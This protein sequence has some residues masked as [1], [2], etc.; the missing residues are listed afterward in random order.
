MSAVYTVNRETFLKKL[1]H[2]QPG[3]SETEKDELAQTTHIVFKSG[4]AISFNAEVSCRCPS[5]LEKTLSAAVKARPLIDSLQKLTTR[6]I[7][8]TFA[9]KRLVVDAR[10]RKI[11]VP[12][13]RKIQLKFGIVERPVAWQPLRDDFIEAIEMATQCTGKNEEMF[14]T[15]C[16]HLHPKGIEACDSFQVLRYKLRTGVR[17]SVLVRGDAIKHLAEMS[18]M[19]QMCET[20]TWIHFKNKR[21]FIFSVRRHFGYKY[22]DLSKAIGIE[23]SP[24]V[25]PRGLPDEIQIAE[26]FSKSEDV[27]VVTV[28]IDNG[29]MKMVGQGVQGKFIGGPYKVKYKGPGVEFLVA[30]NLLS[31]IVKKYNRCII[32]R[33]A[34]KIEGD[35]W[36]YLCYLGNPSA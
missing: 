13:D 18:S 34:I 30:P 9:N 28:E 3:L 5:G 1:L 2:C 6:D 24:A 32:A 35:K 22:I 20:E 25:L 31:D 15:V 10:H 21:D 29:Q 19:T 36:V 4:W 26:I 27:N 33:K 8:L 11:M 16:V 17:E 14:Y 23:G 12:L 7:T